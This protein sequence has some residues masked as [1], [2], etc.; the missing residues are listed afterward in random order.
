MDPAEASRMR[1]EILD[2]V[3]ALLREQLAASEW[4]RVLVEV[5][6]GA[7]GEPA[8]AN[9][10]VEEIVGDEGR[11]DAVFA[12]EGMRAV[13][14]VLAKAAEALCAFDGLDLADVRGGTFV[15]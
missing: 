1:R 2:D 14:P 7:D 8:V 5:V 11:V 4:G 13:L 9:I 3:G 15:R 6:R 10:D 12:G